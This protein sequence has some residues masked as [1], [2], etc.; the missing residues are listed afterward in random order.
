VTKLGKFI[1]LLSSVTSLLWISSVKCASDEYTLAGLSYAKISFRKS[2]LVIRS[3]D[4]IHV[5]K[6]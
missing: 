1:Q 6:M 3:L 4:E 2:A 5:T